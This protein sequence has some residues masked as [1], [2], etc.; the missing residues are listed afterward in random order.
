MSAAG[1]VGWVG[2][3]KI[4]L[5]MAARAVAGGYTVHGWD[6]V[7]ARR[8]A[9]ASRGV[10]I[11][12]DP[13]DAGRRAERFVV[14]VVRDAE[15]VGDSLLGRDGALAAGGRV[16][17]VMSSIGARALRDLARHVEAGRATLLDAPILGNPAGAEA[18][19]LTIPISGPVAEREAARPLLATFAARVEELGE[20][21][22][23]AQIVKAA[24][25]QL[26]IL[27]MVATIEA[28]EF[29]VGAGIDS[30]RLLDVL[31][32]D[33]PSWATEN[34]DYAHG[35]WEAGDPATSLGL[36][37]KDLRAALD[38]GASAGVEMPLTECGLELIV[39][40]LRARPA[41]GL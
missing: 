40:R 14:C 16:G 30:G 24:S 25:Q 35:L 19:T 28:M 18:G 2:L 13:R 22:G 8:E 3:G 26:Q 1:Q 36:F 9:A 6:P 15:Q 11:A 12:A 37:A 32:A 4:G 23:D 10:E 41:G 7:A 17:L 29:A 38:D 20:R 33:S 21:I 39:E 31:N 5:P 27:G 34:W